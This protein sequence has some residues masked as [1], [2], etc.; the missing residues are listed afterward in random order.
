MDHLPSHTTRELQFVHGTAIGMSSKWIKGQYCS[1]LTAAGIVGCGIY[2]MQTPAEFDQAIAIARGTPA[3]PLVEPEDLL[4]A[5][6]VDCT[7]K[8]KQYGISIGMS[9]REAV[10]LMLRVKPPEANE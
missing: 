6:I 1:I 3:H 9:G 8:A 10:E 2:D 7:P 4:D 5:K